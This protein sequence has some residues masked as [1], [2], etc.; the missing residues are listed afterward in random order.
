MVVVGYQAPALTAEYFAKIG[1]PKDTKILDTA[2]GTGLCA[3]IVSEARDIQLLFTSVGSS[4][5]AVVHR[6]LSFFLFFIL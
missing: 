4:N 1:L 3:M 2:C 6:L 5:T